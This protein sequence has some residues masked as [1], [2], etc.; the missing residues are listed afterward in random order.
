MCIRDSLYTGN[1][2]DGTPVEGTSAHGGVFN[3]RSDSWK[4]MYE[5][6]TGGTVQVRPPDTVTN[7]RY[8][9]ITAPSTAAPTPL[10]I[11]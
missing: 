3:A 10:D 1:Y 6:F 2:E 5:V 8:G 7:T 9:P 11:P 4:N